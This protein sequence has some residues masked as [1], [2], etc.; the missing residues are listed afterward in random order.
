MQSKK[1]QV[2]EQFNWIFAIVAGGIILIFFIFVIGQL[3][4]TSEIKLSTK[5][6]Q[7][8]DAILAG[9]SVTPNSLN[10]VDSSKLLKFDITCDTDGYSDLRILQSRAKSLDL[11]QKFI[12]SPSIVTGKKLYLYVLP[13]SNPFIIGNAILLSGDNVLFVEN[14]KSETDV[15]LDNLFKQ[16]P[17]N[18][19]KQRSPIFDKNVL[20]FDKIVVLSKNPAPDLTDRDDLKGAKNLV[21]KE[22]LWIELSFSDVDAKHA[23]VYYKTDKEKVFRDPESINLPSNEF[24]LFLAYSKNLDFYKCNLR[25]IN[26]KVKILSK[27]FLE[28]VNLYEETVTNDQCLLD[29]DSA[30]DVLNNIISATNVFSIEDEVE[31]LKEINHNLLLKSCP[32]IY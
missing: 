2:S 28:K 24:A 3:K 6:L 14:L 8:F 7:N 16:F 9:S 32:L 13:I 20:S 12:F 27:V 19:S 23:K 15:H 22:V 21:K 18:I 4:T 11:S 5:V 26:L 10:V 1:S 29:Y 25:K 31:K 17:D 30:T